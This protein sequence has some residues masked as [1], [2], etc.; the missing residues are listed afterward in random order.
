MRCMATQ[1]ARG[2]QALRARR[3]HPCRPE[4][5]TTDPPAK[6]ERA[7]GPRST[8]ATP[9]AQSRRPMKRI[10][11][12]RDRGTRRRSA[13][14][15][16]T[17]DHHGHAVPRI[18]DR[19]RT[20]MLPWIGSWPAASRASRSGCSRAPRPGA[21]TGAAHFRDPLIGGW[22]RWRSLASVPSS[23]RSPA[24]AS[25]KP[26]ADVVESSRRSCPPGAGGH[27]MAVATGLGIRRGPPRCPRIDASRGPRARAL[28]PVV[29]GC[30]QHPFPP[31]F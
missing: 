4:S 26:A 15:T 14:L 16:T 17:N 25:D 7:A 21:P 30:P 13:P 23:T 31:V 18:H 12:R 8:G 10:A 1:V 19:A 9:A 2:P 28:A 20:R 11:G 6:P 29:R 5:I 3:R 27:S 22:R 24:L